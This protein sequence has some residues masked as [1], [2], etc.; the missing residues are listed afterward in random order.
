MMADRE[1]IIEHKGGGRLTALAAI[2]LAIVILMLLA[3]FFGGDWFG[4]AGSATDVETEVKVS[5]S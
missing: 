4:T 1:T 3:Y 5:S 2:I